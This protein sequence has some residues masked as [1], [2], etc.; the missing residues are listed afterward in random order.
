M[1]GALS[2]CGNATDQWQD[3]RL[4]MR[5]R[6]LLLPVITSQWLSGR[7]NATDQQRGIW[8]GVRRITRRGL[9]PPASQ[10]SGRVGAAMPQTHSKACGYVCVEMQLKRFAAAF[11]TGP[12][13]W[14]TAWDT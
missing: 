13:Q 12:R 14:S 4:L 2:G 6:G 7:S 9:L 5:M 11:I 3:V 8:L 10:A 1:D